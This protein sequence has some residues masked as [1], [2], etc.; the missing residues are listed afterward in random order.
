M[1]KICFL[2]GNLNSSGGTER[3]TSLISSELANSS[4]HEVIIL[5][6]IDGRKP[7]FPI[8][9][10]IK[11]YSLYSKKI[12]FKFNFLGAV[13]KIRKF[14]QEHR[15]ETLIVVDSISCLFTV[16]A[17]M[18]LK[19]NHIC[20][21]HFNF[22]NN[23]GVKLR[24]IGRK[25]A[26]KHCDYI[27]TL[28]N[29]DKELW[30]H[31]LNNI[32]AEIISIP[33][34]TPYQNIKPTPSLDF[35]TILAVGRLTKV[36]GFDLLIEAWCKVCKENQDWI[37]RLVGS[38]EEEGNLKKLVNDKKLNKRIEFIPANNNITEF[39]KTSS[40]FCLSSRFEGFPMVLLEAQAFGLP[41][42]AFDCDTG[43]AEIIEHNI[44]GIVVKK[45]DIDELS[46]A[47]LRLIG[48]S[49]NEYELMSSCSSE[50]SQHYSVEYIAKKWKSII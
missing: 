43:P 47:L 29:R 39:Y 9:S 8:S 46:K 24:E 6:L 11:I 27:I 21:E 41:I 16:P 20:W 3:V 22:N 26:A 32:Q 50:N 12:S 2:I 45:E 19:V 17:L 13:W 25:W 48:L 7:F 14:I 33:N 35:K 49:K 37:L 10:N 30:I 28:T 23:N 1:K 15:I 44:N 4:N 38:G 5:S 36:K 42:V 34:P 18:K 31:N 40:L